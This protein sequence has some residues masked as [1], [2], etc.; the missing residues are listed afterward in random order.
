MVRRIIMESFGIEKYIDEHLNSTNY[1]FPMMKYTPLDDEEQEPK[2]GLR[3]H[4]DTNFI[5]ILHQYQV[6]GL[7]VK[8]KDEKWIKVKP[9]QDRFLVMIGD[10]LSVSSNIFLSN[11]TNLILSRE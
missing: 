7:Q 4:T 6:D 1:L 9:S 8:T 2:Q 5:T 3:S 11:N 10:T